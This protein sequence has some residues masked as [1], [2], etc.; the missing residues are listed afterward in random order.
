MD[1]ADL[2]D[3]LLNNKLRHL[4][5]FC[6]EELALQDIYIN[7]IQE[8]SGLP[9]V[10]ADSIGS[11]YTRLIT[12]SFIKTKP[13]LYLIRN[14]DSYLSKESDWKTL[15]ATKSF[16]GNIVILLVSNN[17][18]GGAFDKAHDEILTYFNTMGENILVN[19]MIATTKMPDEYCKDLVSMCGCSYGRLRNEFYKLSMFANLNGI[20]INS[21]YLEA[22]KS[23]F[24]HADVGNITF[25]FT[26][27]IV[28][29]KI[30]TAYNLW[31][32][33][34]E[35]NETLG[36]IALLYNAFRHILMVQCTDVQ[37]RT[38]QVLGL[39]SAQIY[40]TTKQC[41]FYN[42]VELVNIV[43][44]LRYLEKGIKTGMVDEVYAIE[45]LMGMIW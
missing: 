39:T 29:R 44:T 28:Y 8:I 30:V 10:R 35:R 21:A 13:N 20:S 18:K 32:T 43:K 36:I 1:I 23:N 22:K 16:G 27:A 6:G 41:G 42:S 12:K 34:K 2:K 33:L 24:I 3:E 15:L 31:K 37:A 25:D 45:Y 17:K 9:I 19:R 4:Y 38:E 7:K 5:I 14:D 40:I 11:I 26:N